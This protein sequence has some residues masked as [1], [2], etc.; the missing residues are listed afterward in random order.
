MHRHYCQDLNVGAS[1]DAGFA[2][3]GW[4]LVQSE[5]VLHEKSP[6]EM[7]ELHLANIRNWG[8][9]DFAAVAFDK[10]EL[11]Q[12][13]HDLALI[14]SGGQTAGVVHNATR[15]VIARRE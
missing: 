12:L 13:E 3:T 6:R 4:R 9:G 2:G 14:A 1:L 7:A 15:R 8:K 11:E 10:G 5:R